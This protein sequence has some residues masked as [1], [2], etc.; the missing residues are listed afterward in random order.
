[1]KSQKH[2]REQHWTFKYYETMIAIGAVFLVIA[3]YIYNY[4]YVT[5]D[6][7]LV[8]LLAACALFLGVVLLGQGIRA[9]RTVKEYQDQF[10]KLKSKKGMDVTI[11]KR[12]QK[13]SR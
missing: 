1:M 4:H 5:S 7:G 2:I 10:V 13:W 3:I 12:R 9:W 8:G 6:D 11:R